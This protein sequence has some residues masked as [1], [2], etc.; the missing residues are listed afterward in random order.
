MMSGM[1]DEASPTIDDFDVPPPTQEETVE[2]VESLSEEIALR[3]GLDLKSHKTKQEIDRLLRDEA[4]QNHLH[5]IIVWGL[6]IVALS[7]GLMFLAV[8]YH[9]ISPYPFL[10]PEQ[11]VDIKQLLFSGGVGAAT[12]GLA[13]KYLGLGSEK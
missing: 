12:S 13:K 8:V 2:G 5:R 1:P 9:Y 4:V 3:T 7:A 6:Y 11:L 10:K